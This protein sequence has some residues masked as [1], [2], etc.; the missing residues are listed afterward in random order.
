MM[1]TCMNQS[2]ALFAPAA[3]LPAGWA[4]DVLLRWDAQGQLTQVEAGAVC[5]PGV[6]QAAGPLLPGMPNLHSHAFQRAFAGLT[7]YRASAEDDFW[8][9]RHSMYQVANRLDPAMLQVIARWL[10]IE[11]LQAGYTSVCEFHY[12]HQD[13]DGRPYA[14]AAAMS[15]ALLAAAHEVG[16]G[17]T[18]L[19]VLYQQGG[20]GGQPPTAGQRRFIRS[21]EALLQMIEQLRPLCRA[22]GQQIGL[23][24]HSLRA[25]QPAALREAVQALRAQDAW[26]P[27]HIH[28]A[29]QQREVA[30]CLAW[31]G[32]RP[33]EWLLSQQ[34]VDA[35]W[36][37]VHATHLDAAE[38]QEL[39]QCGA[40]AGLCLT[41]EANL[42]D[43]LFPAAAY[44][45]AGGQWGIGSDSHISVSPWQELRLLEYGQRLHWQRRNVLTSHQQPD[46]ATR[47]YSAAVSGGARASGR[48]I[49]GLAVGQQADF[50]LLAAADPLLAGLPA[51]Q[52]LATVLFALPDA[53]GLDEVWVG[54]VRR[55]VRGQHLR[56]HDAAQAFAAVRRQLMG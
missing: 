38:C 49:D 15:A 7:E 6:V 14:E 30:D 53:R 25:V 26:A 17:L 32:Q 11:M 34:L 24:P 35:H 50:V 29:E 1:E 42:G 39:A 20:F 4:T 41:T 21:T 37:L 8:S 54:G 36:C 12:V 47:L 2:S 31:C 46:L 5:P 27:V 28:I 3:L 52:Q 16:I 55:I 13:A 19:P 44:L 23:A 40:V 9:W 18:L 48:A 51:P 45:A 22:Q 56:Q 10:Y 33:V 43:G